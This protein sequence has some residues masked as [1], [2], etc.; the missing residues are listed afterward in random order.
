MCWVHAER[1]IHKLI[2][3]ENADLAAA[4][5]RVRTQV[6]TLYRGFQAYRGSP[7]APQPAALDAEFDRV[8]T[9]K[10]CFTALNQQ[11][12]RL[13]EHKNELLLLV[14]R[15]HAQRAR[16]GMPGHLRQPKEDLPQARHVLLGVPQDCLGAT[17]AIVPLPELIQRRMAQPA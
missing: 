10:M 17:G 16:P 5:K 11:L 9:Q 12:A 13:Y 1:L 7:M 8:F 15:R 14:L 4:Q 6:W 2:A 3:G